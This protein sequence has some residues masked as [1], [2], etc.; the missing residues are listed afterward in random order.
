MSRSS[1]EVPALPSTNVSS[2]RQTDPRSTVGNS[3][4]GYETALQLALHGARVYIGSR[5]RERVEKAISEMQQS[6]PNQRLDLRFFQLDLQDLRAVREAAHWFTQQE[7]RLDILI[8][9]AGIMGTPFKLTKD[10]Y[11]AQWQVNYLAAFALT[12][13]LLP[14]MLNTASQHADK[15]RV[16]VVNL[17]TEMTSMTGPKT[18]QLHDTSMS[19]NKGVMA[20]FQ[21]YSHAKQ[22]SIRN[23]KELNDRFSAQGLSPLV[24]IHVQLQH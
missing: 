11:E 2:V 4:I 5:S 24:H 22:G 10:G 20:N 16:R 3:G 9:N 12:T 14:L 15:T 6:S 13:S 1:L 18:M 21:R 19:Q 7:P 17:S 8:N 23:A